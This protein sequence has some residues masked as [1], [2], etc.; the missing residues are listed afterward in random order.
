M[1]QW[2][3]DTQL[4]EAAS[5][6]EV[7]KRRVKKRER[8]ARHRNASFEAEAAQAAA[9]QRKMEAAYEA[10]RRAHDRAEEMAEAKKERRHERRLRRLRAE[11]VRLDDAEIKRLQKVWLCRRLGPLHPGSHGEGCRTIGCI[12]PLLVGRED[13]LAIRFV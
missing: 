3:L 13:R 12:A 2:K 5:D 7:R 8:K 4:R 6:L 10:R 11:A 9:Q 1:E